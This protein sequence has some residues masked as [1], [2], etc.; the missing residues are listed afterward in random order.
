MASPLRAFGSHRVK[1]P[2]E[3]KSNTRKRRQLRDIAR[4]LPRTPGVYFFYGHENRL[5]YIGKAKRLR[6]RV[7]SYFA[8]TS[9][10]RP[11]KLRRLLAEI[12]RLEVRHCG[13][14]LEALLLERKLIAQLRPILN[15]QLKRFDVYPYLLLS[16]ET[17]PRL[18]LTRAEPVQDLEIESD[19]TE[20]EYDFFAPQF[21]S[22]RQQL[23]QIP[24]TNELDN[25]PRAGEI[26][27]LYLGPFTTPRAAWWTFEAVRNLFPLRSCEGELAPDANGRGCFYLELKRC[28]GP[29][30]AA[31]QA[32]EY[33]QLCDEL[34]QTLH[35][36]H[37]PQLDRM[38]ARMNELAEAWRFEEAAK[39]KEQLEAIEHVANRLQRLQ[40]MRVANNLVIM[41][42]AL[43]PD[44]GG[45][46]PSAECEVASSEVAY[47]SAF[48]VCAGIVRR[49]VVVRDEAAGWTQLK[50]AI[51]DV[52]AAPP[53]VAPFTA[54]SEL[55][56]MMI[57]DR[58]LQ[59]HGTENCCVWLNERPSRLWATNAMRRCRKWA[60]TPP[61]EIAL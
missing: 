37:S 24:T 22:R 16:D 36:G 56:E 7:R 46:V 6:D 3:G 15:R 34:V 33:R 47:W 26:P 45:E 2:Y 28:A 43:A 51:E 10:K 32:R 29:C 9:L 61:P 38:R 18:T 20:R 11:P 53:P 13:S 21:S 4:A 8:E 31:I 52:F 57:L 23:P 17:F 12:E 41:Q 35:S 60:Q 49:H 44:A 42:P 50:R 25:V 55:D 27:G 40:R 48:L 14:E 58:W 19:E 39:I 59:A 30:V 54:K 5:L 1:K